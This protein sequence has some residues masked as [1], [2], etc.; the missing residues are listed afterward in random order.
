MNS[1]FRLNA[2]V[3]RVCASSQLSCLTKKLEKQKMQ[4][5]MASTSRLEFRLIL[6]PQLR[7]TL[8]VRPALELLAA[9][10]AASRRAASL[11][12]RQTQGIV[13]CTL[14]RRL[15]VVTD[16][17]KNGML[18]EPEA[19]AKSQRARTPAATRCIVFPAELS[20]N[21]PVRGPSG[22]RTTRASMDH[23]RVTMRNFNLGVKSRSF[24]ARTV[25]GRRRSMKFSDSSSGNHRILEEHMLLCALHDPR[26]CL[27]SIR[28]LQHGAQSTLRTLLGNGS[29][30]KPSRRSELN[31]MSN[32]VKSMR[33]GASL[34]NRC[35]SKQ[36][37]MQRLKRTNSGGT[38]Q[39]YSLGGK[40]DACVGGDF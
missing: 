13:P 15:R 26:V 10:P 39:R 31:L 24:A 2:F 18:V 16:R 11:A 6:Q 20:R 8:L 9:T 32:H 34:A 1:L 19:K 22:A 23:D 33:I 40:R 36:I 29:A 14:K 12:R 38:A 35:D 5:S 30:A 7:R 28:Q 21:L 37:W 17:N 3:T 4:S 27:M 25:D